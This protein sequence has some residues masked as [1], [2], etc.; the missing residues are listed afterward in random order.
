MK[1]AKLNDK[2]EIF[3]SIQGEGKNA[4]K[5]CWF[6]RTSLCN[7]YCH[8]CDTDYTW[9]WQGTKF[10]HKRDAHPGYQKFAKSEHIIE[11]TVSEIVEILQSN[12]T[13]HVVL[14]GGEPLLQQQELCALMTE[15]RHIDTN[16]FFETETNGTLLPTEQFDERI[17]QYNVS[18][19][20]ANSNI[21][22][23]VRDSE[24]VIRFLV[25]SPKAHFKFVIAAE[26]DLDEII[27]WQR[28]YEVPSE[29]IY[30]MPQGSTVEEL[31]TTALLVADLCK[32]QGFWFSDRI[33]VRLFGNQRGT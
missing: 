32:Q 29:R 4:G 23:S 21:P 25:N 11:L 16:Y 22:L 24:D 19:K 1:L 3:H 31:S 18:P 13:R 6:V 5:P 26:G 30:L 8:W 10:S 33:H 15:L 12:N 17:S 14:T 2:A 20:L 9:N 7:L 28:K 27:D